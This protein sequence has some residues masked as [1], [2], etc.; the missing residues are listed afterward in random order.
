MKKL[1]AAAVLVM[2]ALVLTGCAVTP[3]PTAAESPEFVL[4]DLDNNGWKE[5]T[6][7]GFV[8]AFPELDTSVL[9]ELPDATFQYQDE[10]WIVGNG[11]GGFGA[12]DTWARDAFEV[13]DD[14]DEREALLTTGDQLVKLTYRAMN[15]GFI[16]WFFV[17]E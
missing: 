11:A 2:S 8:E 17:S 9:D 15:D 6:L 4:P 16:A 12:I 5:G 1:F 7:D 13:T 14:G 3:A 10:S